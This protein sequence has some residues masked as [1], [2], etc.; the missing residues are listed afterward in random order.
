MLRACQRFATHD[1]CTLLNSALGVLHRLLF[2]RAAIEFH[3]PENRRP[4]VAV[5]FDHRLGLVRAGNGF[6]PRLESSD[7]VARSARNL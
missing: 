7:R 6:R 4:V 2:V 1:W 3:H 5:F